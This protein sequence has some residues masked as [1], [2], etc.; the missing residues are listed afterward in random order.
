MFA[1]LACYVKA[2]PVSVSLDTSTQIRYKCTKFT[3]LFCDVSSIVCLGAGRYSLIELLSCST[4]DH[5]ESQYVCANIYLA[6]YALIS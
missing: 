3:L 6:K 4:R 5:T 2:S 1:L